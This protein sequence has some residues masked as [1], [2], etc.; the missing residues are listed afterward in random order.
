MKMSKSQR[1]QIELITLA[2]RVAKLA[3]REMENLHLKKHATKQPKTMTNVPAPQPNPMTNVP[4][5]QLADNFDKPRTSNLVIE[6][7]HL[8]RMV[9]CQDDIQI[10]GI[11]VVQ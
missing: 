6:S 7:S 11:R 8:T 2:A 5:A 10:R 3:K 4:A 1:Q 9:R